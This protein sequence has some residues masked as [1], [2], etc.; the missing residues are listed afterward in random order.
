M[1]VVLIMFVVTEESLRRF[2]PC[3]RKANGTI[4]PIKIGPNATLHDVFADYPDAFYALPIPINGI[5][6]LSPGNTSPNNFDSA[7]APA[8]EVYF[9][10]G[11]N[12]ASGGLFGY[13]TPSSFQLSEGND[14]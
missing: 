6:A 14:Q 8:T 7:G 2:G 3:A 11:P 12:H 13:I 5:W 10:A 9:T 1:S 4:V